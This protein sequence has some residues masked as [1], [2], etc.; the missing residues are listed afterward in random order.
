MADKYYQKQLEEELPALAKSK[1]AKLEINKDKFIDVQH[2]N[3]LWYGG[4]VVEITVDEET[5]VIIEANGDVRAFLY[6]LSNGRD[7]EQCFVKDSMRSG[8][9][10]DEMRSYLNNDADL[11]AAINQNRLELDN[12]N[13]WEVNVVLTRDG[14]EIFIDL[15]DYLDNILDDNLAVAIK[16]VLDCLDYIVDAAKQIYKN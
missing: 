14:K 2:L 11:I 3:C 1:G 4:Q 15:Y 6:E 16:Q 13:W 10:Y 7:N 5:K 12:N 8:R 9:F